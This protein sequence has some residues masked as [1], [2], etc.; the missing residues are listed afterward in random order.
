MVELVGQESASR[1]SDNGNGGNGIPPLVLWIVIGCV[2]GITGIA[3]IIVS[4]IVCRRCLTDG[5]RKRRK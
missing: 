2:G 4:A 1:S 3:I 5:G